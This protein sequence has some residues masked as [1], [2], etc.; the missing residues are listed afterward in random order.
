M[1]LV[2]QVFSKGEVGT[3]DKLI[4]KGLTLKAMWWKKGLFKAY[5][6]TLSLSNITIYLFT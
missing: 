6:S 5:L 2:H 4:K 3:Y 1:K